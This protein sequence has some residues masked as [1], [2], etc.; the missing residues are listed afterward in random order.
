MA[1]S[2][3]TLNGGDFPRKHFKAQA[4]KALSN[5]VEMTHRGLA[6]CFWKEKNILAQMTQGL[7]WVMTAEVF[8]YFSAIVIEIPAKEIDSAVHDRHLKATDYRGCL[9]ARSGISE[10]QQY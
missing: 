9:E 5:P 8:G 7:P 10:N 1:C 6:K 3:A 2:N 4:W